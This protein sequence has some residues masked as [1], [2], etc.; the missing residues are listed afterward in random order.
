MLKWLQRHRP[1]APWCS[2][3]VLRMPTV[4]SSSAR[5]NWETKERSVFFP[6]CSSFLCFLRQCASV[7]CLRKLRDQTRLP[8]SWYHTW[9]GNADVT[10]FKCETRSRSVK[11]TSFFPGAMFL[12][13]FHVFPQTIRICECS[14]DLCNAN[15][16]TA[17]DN[18]GS[19]WKVNQLQQM[20]TF[21]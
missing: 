15:F 9:T 8:V 1:R 17:G 21:T 2:E 20:S 11:T 4:P 5:T 14:G 12:F 6:P 16:T 18:S 10:E 19:S 3:S 7:N 13:R